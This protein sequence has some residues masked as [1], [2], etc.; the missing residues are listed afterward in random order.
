MAGGFSAFSA[1]RW[2]EAFIA[3]CGD[4]A[5]AAFESLKVM[6]KAVQRLKQRIA[7]TDD[8]C[9][10]EEIVRAAMKKAGVDSTGAEIACRTLALLIR[11]GLFQR[12]QT[13]IEEIE[14]ALD[15]KNGVLIAILETAAPLPAP[16]RRNLEQ[17]IK[18][19]AKAREIRLTERIAPELLGG[20]KL[21]V[22]TRVIDASVGS[23]LQN[24][25]K[26]FAL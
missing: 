7:G 12:S 11:R 16:F 19:T 18:E 6:V 14:K 21:R 3:S 26:Q 9:H 13:L 24:M 5:D 2:A 17:S 25:A 1:D 15:R 20:Y 8:A 10:V 4:D 22:G 23:F